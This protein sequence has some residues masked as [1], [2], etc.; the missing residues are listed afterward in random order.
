MITSCP[1]AEIRASVVVLVEP[2][3]RVVAGDAEVVGQRLGSRR[4]RRQTDDTPPPVLGDPR[5]AKR[6][7]RCG[8]ACTGRTDEQVDLATRRGDALDRSAAVAR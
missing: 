6:A 7:H 5:G 1:R 4:G 2:L 8:L 3:R